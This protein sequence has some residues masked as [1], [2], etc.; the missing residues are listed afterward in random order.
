M[1]SFVVMEF[2]EEGLVS[3]VHESW[4][5]KTSLVSLVYVFAFRVIFYGYHIPK[6]NRICH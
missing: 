4:I 2:L 3:A 5:E 6:P 1:P